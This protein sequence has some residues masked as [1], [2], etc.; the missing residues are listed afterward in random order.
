MALRSKENEIK[1][2]GLSTIPITG[3]G[4]QFTLPDRNR[5]IVI[6]AEAS[7]GKQVSGTNW[8]SARCR[9]TWADG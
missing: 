3:S 5:V 2:F 9:G 1:K 6:I 8:Y 4:I 7:S